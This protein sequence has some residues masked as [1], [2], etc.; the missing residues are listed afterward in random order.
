MLFNQDK[1]NLTQPM[2]VTFLPR[3]YTPCQAQLGVK[4]QVA[5]EEAP[6]A[7]L[8]PAFQNQLFTEPTSL[9]TLAARNENTGLGKIGTILP[10]PSADI[11]GPHIDL[12][13]LMSEQNFQQT[14]SLTPIAQ[15]RR[16]LSQQPEEQAD[17]NDTVTENGATLQTGEDHNSS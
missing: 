15:L 5:Q 14:Q 9:V 17:F 16:G 8:T 6:K 3:D 7:P 4:S 11:E 12:K 1:D 2:R 10:Q 13:R